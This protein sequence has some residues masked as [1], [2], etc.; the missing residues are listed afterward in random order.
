MQCPYCNYDFPHPGE[1]VKARKGLNEVKCNHC[2]RWFFV[3]KE[4]VC[5]A[6]VK[7]NSSSIAR[8]IKPIYHD[9]FHRGMTE[10]VIDW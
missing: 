9:G 2:D 5:G 7:I 3:K 8:C 10:I 1:F 4:R 6:T